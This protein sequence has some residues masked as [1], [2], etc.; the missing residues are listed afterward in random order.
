M[1]VTGRGKASSRVEIQFD[2]N[3]NPAELNKGSLA[4]HYPRNQDEL[5]KISATG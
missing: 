5:S 4:Q 3:F 2:N 1:R